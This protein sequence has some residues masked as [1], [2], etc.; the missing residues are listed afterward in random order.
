M[1]GWPL[2]SPG[3]TELDRYDLATT[4]LQLTTVTASGTAHTKGSWVELDASTSQDTYLLG[5]SLYDTFVS[6]TITG[7]LVD[8]GVGGSGSEVV[9]ISNILAGWQPSS[10]M[11]SAGFTTPTVQFPI[12][13]PSGTRISARCQA[14][15]VSDTVSVGVRLLGGA[16][17]FTFDRARG[18]NVVTYGA[19]TGNSR[20]TQIT[21]PGSNH[22]KGAWTQITSSTTEPHSALVISA[23]GHTDTALSIQPILLDVGFGAAASEQVLLKD[24]MLEQSSLE[25]LSVHDVELA[26]LSIGRTL[27]VGIRLAV[28]IQAQVFQNADVSLCLHG[29]T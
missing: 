5:V 6:S 3:F 8:I 27:P 14:L 9:L 10:T 12:Y 2:A 24:I 16:N 26:V 7:V 13:V 29:I 21:A 1:S 18:G 17:S 4:D 15:I 22:T 23:Q 25:K 19:D 20:G 11:S 28:R